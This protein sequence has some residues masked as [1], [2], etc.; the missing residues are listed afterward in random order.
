MEPI[1]W[2]DGARYDGETLTRQ[3]K[4]N[5]EQMPHVLCTLA[6]DVLVDSNGAVANETAITELEL[7]I[8][9]N[10]AWCLTW[11][12]LA[13]DDAGD[14][15]ASWGPGMRVPPGAVANGTMYYLDAGSNHDVDQWILDG[16]ATDDSYGIWN[17]YA[18][19]TT[20]F[21]DGSLC[22]VVDILVF[23]T[24]GAGLMQP[25]IRSNSGNTYVKAGTTIIGM[26]M[27]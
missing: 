13:Q 23:G 19:P 14:Q 7:P 27:S 1:P 8:E 16:S 9:I 2:Q 20:G 24:H 3:L 25:T 5:T 10:E 21:T 18:A 12:V 11:I 17:Q 6:E 4:V 15:P 26:K 22:V